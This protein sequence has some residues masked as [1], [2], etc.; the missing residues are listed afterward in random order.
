MQVFWIVSFVSDT[1]CAQIS[2]QTSARKTLNS[3]RDHGNKKIVKQGWSPSYTC[4]YITG[5]LIPSS[6]VVID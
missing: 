1:F 5:H 2:E 3:I 6:V 4:R